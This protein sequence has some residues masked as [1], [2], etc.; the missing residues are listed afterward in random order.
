MDLIKKDNIMIKKNND[1]IYKI[2]FLLNWH[3]N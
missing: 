2:F 1:N 3:T